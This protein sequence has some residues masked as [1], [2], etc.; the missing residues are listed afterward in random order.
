MPRFARAASQA[1]RASSCLTVLSRCC[2]TTNAHVG[3]AAR[4]AAPPSIEDANELSWTPPDRARDWGR[5]LDRA[6]D[7]AA[8]G[9]LDTDRAADDARVRR[10]ADLSRSAAAAPES[11]YRF[12]R[13]RVLGLRWRVSGSGAET[14]DA[15]SR[16]RRGD[17]RPG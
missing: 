13:G 5:N 1:D 6:R 15:S 4:P 7:H 12:D 11:A 10:V 3:P 14:Q 2:F 9:D 16:G 17:Y 8:A